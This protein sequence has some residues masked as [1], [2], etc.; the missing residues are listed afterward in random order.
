MRMVMR[1]FITGVYALVLAGSGIALQRMPSRGDSLEMVMTGQLG[2]RRF[3]NSDWHAAMVLAFAEPYLQISGRSYIYRRRA[4]PLGE[5]SASR[6][7]LLCAFVSVLGI[8]LQDCA[9]F[10]NK[11]VGCETTPTRLVSVL[12]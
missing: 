1:M 8:A 3:R 10:K 5:G 9:L 7:T 6:Y 2:I 11:F 4:R 12:G